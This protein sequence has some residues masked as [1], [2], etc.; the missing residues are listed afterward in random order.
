[1]GGGQ[2]EKEGWGVGVSAGEA[3][4]NGRWGFRDVACT[5]RNAVKTSFGRTVEIVGTIYLYF[6]YE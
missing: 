1:V 6:K 2:L 4:K 3:E 5:N